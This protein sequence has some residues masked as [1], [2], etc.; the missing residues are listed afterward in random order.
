[1]F[2]NKCACKSVVK[3]FSTTNSVH[4]VFFV[5]SPGPS[6]THLSDGPDDRS[7]ALTHSL[8]VRSEPYLLLSGHG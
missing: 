3:Y 4:S 1:M 6:S 7:A 5:P 2:G 8:L